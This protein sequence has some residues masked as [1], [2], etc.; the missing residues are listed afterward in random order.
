MVSEQVNNIVGGGMAAMSL[1]AGT[2]YTLCSDPTPLIY[3]AAISSSTVAMPLISEATSTA[4]KETQNNKVEVGSSAMV[5]AMVFKG[6]SNA[7]GDIIEA[8][9]DMKTSEDLMRIYTYLQ[10][11]PLLSKIN[12]AITRLANYLG[13]VLY[14][15]PRLIYVLITVILG[16]LSVIASIATI[17]KILT[18]ITNR[19]EDERMFLSTGPTYR[20]GRPRRR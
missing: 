5:S 13:T 20:R 6:G 16:T 3:P 1:V 9:T 14:T 18:S 7:V 8:A 15:C 19:K 11:T 12:P 4:L 2:I 10:T 17:Y